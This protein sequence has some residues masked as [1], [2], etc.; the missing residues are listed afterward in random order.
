MRIAIEESNRKLT[1]PAP[2]QNEHHA[3]HARLAAPTADE[4]PCFKAF[5]VGVRGFE[6]P[7]SCSQSAKRET[8]YKY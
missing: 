7:T 1:I 6:P 5:L 8:A 2:F 3:L 4:A